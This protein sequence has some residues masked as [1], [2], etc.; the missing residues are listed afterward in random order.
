MRKIYSPLVFFLIL[1]VDLES[2]DV[3]FRRS[4]D[5]NSLKSAVHLVVTRVT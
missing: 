5:S 2:V 3:D 1:T 4:V